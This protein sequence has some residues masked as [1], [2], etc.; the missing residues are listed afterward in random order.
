MWYPADPVGFA[1]APKTFYTSRLY[2]EPLAGLWDPLSWKIEARIARE[3]AA[4]EPAGRAYPVIVFSHGAMNDPIDFAYTLELIAAAG[5]VVAAPAHVNNTQDDVR[6]DYVNT[7]ALALGLPPVFGCRDGLASPCNR[8]NVARSMADRARD[9]SAVLAALPGWYGDRVDVS[10]AGLMGHS[11]GTVTALVAAGGS[12]DPLTNG[13]GATWGIKA[14][15]G[16]KAVMGLAIGAPAI[17][18]CTDFAK[19]TVP[20]L[21]VAGA[22]DTTPGPAVSLVAHTRLVASTDKQ[23]VELPGTLHRSFASTYCAQMQ[24]AGAVAGNPRAILDKHTFDQILTSSVQ[25]RNSPRSIAHW[26][27]SPTP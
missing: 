17:T 26:L 24:A 9:I 16:I 8:T 3:Q 12:V 25:C 13:C 23:F 6:M 21:L 1:D 10:R 2:G 5:F 14:L 20:V 27:P 19:V 7:K 4:I 15:P 22:L 18:Y 11:R